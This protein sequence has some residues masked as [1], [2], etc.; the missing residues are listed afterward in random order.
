MSLVQK[1]EELI[2]SLPLRMKRRGAAE[3]PLPHEPRRVARIAQAVSD[4]L[5]I[6]GQTDARRR[7]FRADGI[8]LKTK[9]RLIPLSNLYVSVLHQLGL[10]DKSFGTSTGTLKGLDLV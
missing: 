3:M 1:A 2:E 7:V 4:G 10:A 9:P 5:F 8:E 6:Y